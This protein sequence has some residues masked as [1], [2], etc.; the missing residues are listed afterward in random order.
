MQNE[1]IINAETGETRVALIE[2]K[3]FAELHI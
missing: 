1:I 2:N 3:E